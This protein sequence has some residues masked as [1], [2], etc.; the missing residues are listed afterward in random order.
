MYYQYC[1]LNHALKY[2][3]SVFLEHLQGRWLHQLLGSLFQCITT[4]LE[5]AFLNWTSP[6]QPEA[7]PSSPIASYM[8]EKKPGHVLGKAA[9]VLWV[10]LGLCWKPSWEL[11][12]NALETLDK[13]LCSVGHS[14]WRRRL[15]SDAK[16][17]G[18]TL[19]WKSSWGLPELQS[20]HCRNDG[21]G[22]SPVS[23][24]PRGYAQMLGVGKPF[25]TSIGSQV[26]GNKRDS[27]PQTPVTQTAAFCWVSTCSA[28]PKIISCLIWYH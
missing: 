16:K 22:P 23:G 9:Q 1:P 26:L 13:A 19:L 24:A 7:V 25:L 21:A 2:H 15:S 18:S 14:L 17:A 28:A 20:R 6:V 3:I 27:S 10:P 8:G 5:K 12:I 4:L 11:T